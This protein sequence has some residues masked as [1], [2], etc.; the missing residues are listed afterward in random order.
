MS[1]KTKSIIIG[2]VCGV[3]GVILLAA[4]ILVARRIF[5]NRRNRVPEDDG[6]MEYNGYNGGMSS[7]GLGSGLGGSREKDS[8]VG[9]VGSSGSGPQNPFQSTL[10]SYH[11]PAQARNV[12]SNF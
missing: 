2:V 12:S 9:T 5:A 11:N 7:S 4:L 10:E 6:L 8:T 3:G 1:S